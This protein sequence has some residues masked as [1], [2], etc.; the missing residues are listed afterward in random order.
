MAYVGTFVDAA[1]FASGA[2][3]FAHR[4]GRYAAIGPPKKIPR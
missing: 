4:R 3:V 2:N 1:D